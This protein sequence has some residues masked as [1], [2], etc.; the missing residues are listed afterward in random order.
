MSLLPQWSSQSVV[1]HAEGNITRQPV[2]ATSTLMTEFTPSSVCSPIVI[3]RR[4]PREL[5]VAETVNEGGV[6]SSLVGSRD[7]ATTF[8][9]PDP[10]RNE[11]GLLEAMHRRT[12][13]NRTNM[14]VHSRPR[15]ELQ[16]NF[17]THT[18]D[19][20]DI[21]HPVFHLPKASVALL[22]ME[23]HFSGG[24]GDKLQG[25]VAAGYASTS[26]T[27]AQHH[28][29]DGS[30]NL[31]QGGDTVFD[32]GMRHS[33]GRQEK[34]CVLGSAFREKLRMG[35]SYIN[36]EEYYLVRY[37]DYSAWAVKQYSEVAKRDHFW[38]KAYIEQC[39]AVHVGKGPG[40]LIP[41]TEA[42]FIFGVEILHREFLERTGMA[43]TQGTACFALTKD[44]FCSLGVVLSDGM[45][46]VGVEGEEMRRRLAEEREEEGRKAVARGQRSLRC[47][48]SAKYLGLAT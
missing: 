42:Q 16:F 6:L 44:Q 29:S 33:V 4:D 38:G 1:V 15:V 30:S 19:N 34:T 39:F 11:I 7:V 21:S 2:D 18:G 17:S 25:G 37:R 28:A 23:H 27:M 46:A 9:I 35:M 24:N 43:K 48:Y 32:K 5:C 41:I 10:A 26:D 3:R 20:I 12:T 22:Q 45:R 36:D 40:E 8:W 31:N 47:L 14:L 13:A